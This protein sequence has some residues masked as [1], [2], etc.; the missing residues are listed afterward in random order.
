[1]KTI[2]NTIG[3]TL[4]FV[5]IVSA[6]TKQEVVSDYH[7]HAQF[8][9]LDSDKPKLYFFDNE[10][11]DFREN[12]DQFALKNGY[13][14]IYLKWVNPLKYQLKWKDSVY[15]DS[16]FESIRDFLNLASGPL[17]FNEESF[18]QL[19]KIVNENVLK[20]KKVNN[21]T[22]ESPEEL[23][24]AMVLTMYMLVYD[25]FSELSK[26][27]KDIERFNNLVRKLRPIDDLKTRKLAQSL[28]DGFDELYAIEDYSLVRK[29][30]SD[31]ALDDISDEIE[32]IRGE[33]KTIQDIIAEKVFEGS[34]A[35]NSYV[36]SMVSE[37]L[38]QKE[39][40]IKKIEKLYSNLSGH[41]EAMLNSITDES[42][43]Q[44]GYF[45]VGVVNLE[46][47]QASQVKIALQKVNVDNEMI[48]K[49]SATTDVSYKVDFSTYDPV[50]PFVSV[51]LFY[52]SVTVSGYGV[53]T[54]DA[55]E[56]VVTEDEIE[57]NSGSAAAFLNLQF[58]NYS[59]Y[60]AP[61]VQIGIDPT[62]T[63]PFL[64]LG[65]GFSIPVAKFAITGGA[66]WTW[67]AELQ[68]L[69]VDEV[70]QSSTELEN[71]LKFKLNEAKPQGFYLGIQYDF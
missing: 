52:T 19:R 29:S 36:H 31:L 56:L 44:E 68:E 1:M 10:K 22:L 61:I 26:N 27:E 25:Q 28:R 58:F 4:L 57:K 65:G 41:T 9:D 69:Q 24:S 18:P 70:I 3:L 12:I 48:V 45:N 67:Q 47:T 64:L 39:S 40:E 32:E 49:S 55:G 33:T 15:N 34:D 43:K 8:S 37:Y 14:K 2:L 42:P 7:I 30:V 23:R 20:T 71:D 53:G 51:G 62:K 21:T 5:Q 38:T 17:G 54:N 50:H 6:Q 60:L 35:Y 46:E 16:R 63:R 13:A 11:D 59:R 66:I